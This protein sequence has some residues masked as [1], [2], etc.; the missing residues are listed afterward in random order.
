MR[1]SP[2]IVSALLVIAVSCIDKDPSWNISWNSGGGNPVEPA[3]APTP[4]PEPEPDVPVP[5]DVELAEAFIQDFKGP[6][7]SPFS[8][9]LNEDH[10][11][12]R[13][14]PGFP[15]LSELGT[16]ILLIRLD[17]TDGP[18]DGPCLLAAEHTFYGS[19]SFRV[20]TPDLSRVKKTTDA[21][22][23]IRLDGS[24]PAAGISGIGISWKLS[25]PSRI[26]L[27][28]IAGRNA[29]SALRK[30]ET[31]TVSASSDPSLR[32][33]TIGWDWG[34]DSVKW[35]IKNP[36]TGEKTILL[37]ISDAAAVPSIPAIMSI[38]LSYSTMP[39][40]YP[41][42]TEVDMISYEPFDEAIK[43]WRDNIK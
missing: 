23:S 37:E 16:D 14:F 30:E 19:Y 39:P 13:Y 10:A 20:R 38:G 24:D 4:E 12:F 21:V 25:Q 15:S 41:F 33:Q 22:I 42:E 17:P 34:P 40:K 35:W 18:S 32:F 28:S 7:F 31:V 11:D 27:S 26:T 36:S 29:D 5:A 6:D 1:V 8:P 9:V 3:P 43:A 2:L